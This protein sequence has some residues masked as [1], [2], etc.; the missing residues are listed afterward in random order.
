[1]HRHTV[2]RPLIQAERLL[3]TMQG[4]AGLQ[5]HDGLLDQ[6]GMQL[7]AHTLSD[8]DSAVTLQLAQSSVGSIGMRHR[9][10][11]I[12]C[13]VQQMHGAF[14]GRHLGQFRKASRKGQY[15]PRYRL[16]HDSGQ[17]QLSTLR[18]PCQCG[19]RFAQAEAL[20]L[21]AHEI[22]QHGRGLR[23]ASAAVVIG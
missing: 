4:H 15:P 7:M 2:R 23:H 22:E 8:I 21:L 3:P 9:H 10:S 11:C 5:A 13:T 14:G 18:K 16:G 17:G 12:G 6:G 1:M 20:L 19:L